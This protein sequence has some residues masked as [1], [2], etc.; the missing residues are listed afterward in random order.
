MGAQ[1][2]KSPEGGERRPRV[3]GLGG[4]ADP[5]AGVDG[6]RPDL[7]Q[8]RDRSRLGDVF[9]HP[10]HRSALLAQ[11]SDDTISIAP[12]DG[13][14]ETPDDLAKPVHPA[15]DHDALAEALSRPGW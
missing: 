12:A 10:G 2:A 11:Q 5:P 1:Q 13:V 14:A 7:R 6:R 8:R 3:A 4:L 9:V 15:E